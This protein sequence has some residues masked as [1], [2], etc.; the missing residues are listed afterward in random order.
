MTTNP[1]D[2]FYVNF[3]QLLQ[4]VHAD[5]SLQVWASD[6]FRR[7]FV[8]AAANYLE[9]QVKGVLRE[10][11]RS[12]SGSPMVEAFLN[13]TMERM[14]HTYFDW[15]ST[16]ANTFF[17]RFGKEFK[18]LANRDVQTTRALD[19]GIRAFLEIGRTRNELLHE[20]LREVMLQK[21][22]D[23]FYELH[24][25]ALLFVEYLRDKLSGPVDTTSFWEHLE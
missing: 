13:N 22:M 7:L 4:K 3:K 9:S 17:A 14:Y 16:N 25:N 5:M 24:K 11:W 15:E 10:L 21:T 19:D 1:V 2:R 23:E 8:V 12:K 20:E 6:N 18:I